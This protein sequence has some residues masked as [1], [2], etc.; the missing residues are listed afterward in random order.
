MANNIYTEQTPSHHF[1]THQIVRTLDLKHIQSKR[2]IE[3][4][5]NNKR[6]YQL[7]QNE[8]DFFLYDGAQ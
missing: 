4:N 7:S 2:R 1:H 8:H 6:I 3:K 5:E